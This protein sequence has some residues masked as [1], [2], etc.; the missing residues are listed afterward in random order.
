MQISPTTGELQEWL[1]DWQRTAECQVL[2]SWGLICSSQI[3]PRSTP[4]LAAGLRRIFDTNAWWK[5][6]KVGSWQGAFQAS[7]YARLGDGQTALDVVKT[8]LK[9]SVNPNFTGSFPGHT[10]YQ[11]DGTLGMMA[12]MNEM[13]LQSHETVTNSAVVQPQ[14]SGPVYEL[15]LLPALPAEW[16]D[17]SITGLRARGG[18]T[19]NLTWKNS[20]L[21]QATILSRNGSPCLLRLGNQTLFLKTKKGKSYTF[22]PNLRR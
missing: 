11:I 4:A 6:E 12:A 2:S 15:H 22:G 19:V 9:S 10:Q 3:S 16:S 5:K 13:L 14:P 18:F 21:S 8:H 7:A 20:R 1:D 17:G